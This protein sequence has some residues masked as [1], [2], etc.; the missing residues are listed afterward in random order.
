MVKR[1]AL[2]KRRARRPSYGSCRYQFAVRVPLWAAPTFASLNQEGGRVF[3]GSSGFTAPVGAAESSP[4][5]KLW[6]TTPSNCKTPAGVTDLRRLGRAGSR[7]RH[8]HQL[9]QLTE[10]QCKPISPMIGQ[11]DCVISGHE[12]CRGARNHSQFTKGLFVVRRHV[13]DW[14]HRNLTRTNRPASQIRSK[15]LRSSQSVTA[16]R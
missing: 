8:H 2:A 1:G 9:H 14:D 13:I 12:R 6:G 16:S 5:R 7:R 10:R 4:Q 3:W 11:C 15:Y